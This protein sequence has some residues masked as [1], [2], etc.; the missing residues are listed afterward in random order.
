MKLPKGFGGQG[1]GGMLQQAQ[2]AMAKA[3]DL[4]KALE[5]ERIQVDKGP[6]KCV[7]T[8]T[9]EMISIKID[10]AAIDPDDAEMLEDQ[11]VLAVRDGFAQ[12]TK[13]RSDRVQSIMPNIPGLGL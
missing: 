7:F 9:G 12:A 10:P 6:V 1:F 11:I 3:Q 4:E 2:E 8:G 13:L 5:N